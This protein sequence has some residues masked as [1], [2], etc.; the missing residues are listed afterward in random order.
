MRSH[1]AIQ[2]AIAGRTADHAKALHLSFSSVTKWQEPCGDW[3]DSGSHNPLDRIETIM[4]TALAFKNPE[5]LAPLHYLCERFGVLAVPIPKYDCTNITSDMI[6]AVKEF[7]EVAQ[8]VTKA[9]DDNKIDR[10]EAKRIRREGM[11]AVRALLTLIHDAERSA[12]V[13]Q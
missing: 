5:A 6:L 4:N 13:R 11:H 1:E 10:E 7:G 3:S 8:E 12:G 2:Q 9:I